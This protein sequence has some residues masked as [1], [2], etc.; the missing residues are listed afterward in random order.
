MEL[1][2][3]VFHHTK[4]GIAVCN[5]ENSRLEMVNPTYT[6]I[7]GLNTM[8]SLHDQSNCV[9]HSDATLCNACSACSVYDVPFE[10]ALTKKDGSSVYIEAIITPLK[11][12]A[13]EIERKIINIKDITQRKKDEQR[14]I[15]KEKRL[16]EAQKIARLGNW[17]LNFSDNSLIWSDEIYKI[18]EIETDKAPD[19]QHF[20]ERIHPDEREIVETKFHLS[21]MN[22]TPLDLVYRLK[23]DNGRIKHIHSRGFTRY[24]Q[25]G[26][27]I[28]T[29]G[30]I[31]DI[32]ERVILEKNMEYMANH[33][34][35]TGL[36]N[37]KMARET[38]ERLIQSSN[39]TVAIVF[40]D[41]DG[42][43]NIND[44]FGHSVGDTILKSAAMR[45]KTML[46]NSDVIYRL[47][48]DE[49]LLVLSDINQIQDI[50][51]VLHKI[52]EE[53]NRPFDV[54]N[55]IFFISMSIG[56]SLY[57][58]H[59]DTFEVLLQ[60]ADTAMYKAKDNGKNGYFIYNENIN[61]NMIGEF[62]LLKD[63][64]EAIVNNQFE[65]YYQPQ[66]ELNTQ[67]IIG[68]E[69]LIRWKH[70]Q[71]GVVPP[72]QF[73]PICE[74]NG[75]IVEI[76][77]W[78]IY[79][80]CR[81]GA[82]WAAQGKN[83][84]IAVNISA[85]QFKRGNFEKVIKDALDVSGF[86]PR[87]LE[88]ELTESIMIH[89]TDRVL[90]QVNSLKTMGIQL[91]IDDFGTGY[92]SLAYLKR[93]S[94][95]KL[96]IDQS[97]IRDILEN[98]EDAVIVKTIIKMAHSLNLE[99]IAEGVEEPEIVDLLQSFGCDHVQGYYFARPLDVDSF[100]TYYTANF[101]GVA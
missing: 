57:P 51:L 99:A 24:D 96:K 54:S 88:L 49:F 86:D 100:E 3:S 39:K 74:K 32:S 27:P 95:D 76:G 25:E 13:G 101:Q 70:P 38:V 18:F 47:G 19:Y 1:L 11:N 4:V 2:E 10:S 23:F 69:A 66:F 20:I 62:K 67:K 6:Q 26:N 36:P 34:H 15:Q 65:L 87:F 97:F 5:L 16:K 85:I 43:K 58:K 12:E 37:R 9:F 59:G 28:R 94:V 60:K 33:D 90:E 30:T 61:H 29:V 84:T 52:L 89:D 68:A 82:L 72:G 64:K 8:D 17:E 53:F 75:L 40:I 31:Q 91:S 41:L 56:V 79:E 80:A 73:I 77:E 46:R 50:E 22:K 48:G 44:S 45:F 55:H 93:F 71:L 81:Q 42:F 92:S 35:L 83:L 78:V 63:L 7:T 98:Q 21:V 14:F